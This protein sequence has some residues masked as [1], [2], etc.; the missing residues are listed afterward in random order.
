MLYN[1]IA[2]DGK[3]MKPKFT[4]GLSQNG[5]VVEEFEPEVINESICSK[6]TLGK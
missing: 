6:E 5:S 3:M 2:N 4:Y 1:A